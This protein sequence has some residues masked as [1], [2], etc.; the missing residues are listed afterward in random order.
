MHYFQF[1]HKSQLQKMHKFII[2]KNFPSTLIHSSINTS[3]NR[4]HSSNSGGIS[5]HHLSDL[6]I[7]QPEKFQSPI[8][9]SSL[10]RQNK[11]RDLKQI[12][13]YLNVKYNRGPNLY[14]YSCLKK[15]LQEIGARCG[16]DDN[17]MKEFSHLVITGD[18]T[19]ISHPEEFELARTMLH[20]NFV[21]N[22]R[23]GEDFH[24]DRLYEHCTIIPGRLYT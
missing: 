1:R 5:L 16:D 22:M 14:Q 24:V 13:G 19:N 7:W 12:Q 10:F 2:R 9:L 4:S 21:E 11:F 3:A 8:S 23:R 18:V 6:H 15:A 20:E 17:T